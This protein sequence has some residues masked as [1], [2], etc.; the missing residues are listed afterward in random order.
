VEAF[1][2]GFTGLEGF[3]QERMATRHQKK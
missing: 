1:S 2:K 3:I